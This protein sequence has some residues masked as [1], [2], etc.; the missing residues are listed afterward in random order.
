MIAD[1][2]GA[3]GSNRSRR[4]TRF[5]DS[6]RKSGIVIFS[7]A[8]RRHPRWVLK[9]FKAEIFGAIWNHDRRVGDVQ[10]R[11]GF[12]ATWGLTAI[13]PG[14]CTEYQSA[15]PLANGLPG[16][17]GLAAYRR[18][19]SKARMANLRRDSARRSYRSIALS[20]RLFCSSIAANV[21]GN[22]VAL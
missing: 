6:W 5:S 7:M 13:R 18:A 21:S 22:C 2:I 9:G 8:S 14:A 16:S 19:S 10:W 20:C 12:G 15:R 1:D 4:P 17:A 3:K 11:R